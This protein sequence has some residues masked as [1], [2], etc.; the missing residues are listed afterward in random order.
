MN[1]VKVRYLDPP[2]YVDIG[3]IVS[4]YTLSQSASVGGNLNSI[5]NQLTLGGEVTLSNSPT[6]TYTPLTGNAYIKGLTTPLPA[7]TVFGALQN[8]SPADSI[9]LSSVQSING[10]R[11]QQALL[12]G[13]RPADPEFH[14][15][16]NLLRD[17]QLSGLV[18]LYVTEDSE[19][20]QA[21]VL[22]LRSDNVPPEIQAATKEL[23]GLLHLRQDATEFNLVAAPLPS[24]DTEIAVMTRSII[25]ILQNM[26]AEVEVPS[27]HAA[28]HRA[29]PGF[30]TGRTLPG[31]VPM[32]RIHSAKS[33][34]PDAF[35]NIH[36]RDTW[37]WIDDGD[38]VSKRAFAQLMQL[39]TMTDTGPKESQ[40]VVT[41]PSR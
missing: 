3:S 21:T 9:L 33:K 29:F 39:F 1:I 6:I 24:S 8:G 40:P 22:A 2:V 19:K 20:H 35:V 11:N 10:L 28:Q 36:Y 37:F 7:V 41:I 4:S 34:P 27:E 18:R 14:R 31:V 5:S 23:R 32:I 17:I 38:L 13:I 15:V 26:A 16:R 30:E 25:G 12:D